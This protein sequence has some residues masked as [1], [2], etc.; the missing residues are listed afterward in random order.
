M[1]VATMNIKDPG[2]HAAAQEL[3]RR[4]GVTLTEAV[5]EAV[6]DALTRER[7]EDPG[8]VDRLLDLA[9]QVREASDE[10]YLTDNDLYDE[11]GAPR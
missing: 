8:Y 7:K 11:W 2:I 6:N 9:R 10:P 4:R 3:A 1:T 5:R